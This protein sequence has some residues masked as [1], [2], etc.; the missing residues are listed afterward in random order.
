MLGFEI[1]TFTEFIKLTTDQYIID[2]L[3]YK[4]YYYK[5]IYI[6][7][8]YLGVQREII[9]IFQNIDE[10]NYILYLIETIKYRERQY[11]IVRNI[12][13]EKGRNILAHPLTMKRFENYYERIYYNLSKIKILEYFDNFIEYKIY[14]DKI[15]DT[16][17]VIYIPQKNIYNNNKNEFYIFLEKFTLNIQNV[18]NNLDSRIVLFNILSECLKNLDEYKK[19]HNNIELKKE[20][21]ILFYY[22][23]I[24]LMPFKLGTASIAEIALYSLWKYYIGT[25]L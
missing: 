18:Q 24:F 7:F 1:K 23:L 10:K 8:Y 22:I 9:H 6:F 3:E 21:I 17:I 11:G 14:Y 25:E 20:Y 13:F 12:I 19:T 4:E 2:K 16:Y 15:I 5:L